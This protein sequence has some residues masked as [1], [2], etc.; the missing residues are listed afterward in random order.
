MAH[1]ANVRVVTCGGSTPRLREKLSAALNGEVSGIVEL[2]D[3]RRAF[4]GESP[5][6]QL[7]HRV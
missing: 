5:A 3:L 2:R 4:A 1:G 7:H 6:G